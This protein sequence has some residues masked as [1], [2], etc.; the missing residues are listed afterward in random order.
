MTPFDKAGKTV[1]VRVW[2]N[3]AVSGFGAGVN[4]FQLLPGHTA[5]FQIRAVGDNFDPPHHC[6]V[7]LQVGLPG[8]RSAK[9]LLVLEMQSCDDISLTGFIDAAIVNASQTR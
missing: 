7:R 4:Q 1:A 8:S 3:E 5:A 2:G 6:A 9:P